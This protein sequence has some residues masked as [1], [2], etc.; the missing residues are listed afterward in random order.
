MHDRLL[1]Q[2]ARVNNCRGCAT[3]VLFRL[4]GALFLEGLIVLVGD[5]VDQFCE[6]TLVRVPTAK[7]R[8]SATQRGRADVTLTSRTAGVSGNGWGVMLPSFGP[9]YA[10]FGYRLPS[11]SKSVARRLD[12]S[13]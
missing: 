10:G 4:D 2:S 1:A 6:A 8:H 9:C 11:R 3:A 13:T 12:R 5:G 7:G